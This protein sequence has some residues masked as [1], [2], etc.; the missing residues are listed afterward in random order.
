[1]EYS[2]RAKCRIESKMSVFLLVYNNKDRNLLTHRMGLWKKSIKLRLSQNHIEWLS[3]KM[4]V[5]SL[6][7]EHYG[8]QRYDRMKLQQIINSIM[9]WLR[10]T[11]FITYD[12]HDDWHCHLYIMRFHSIQLLT[13]SIQMISMTWVFISSPYSENVHWLNYH[14]AFHHWNF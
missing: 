9:T 7:S 6:K 5:F 3:E 13:S 12:Y 10:V 4:A 11:T 2:T 14:T 8:G 1:M